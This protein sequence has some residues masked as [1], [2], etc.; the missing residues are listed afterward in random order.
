MK[1]LSISKHKLNAHGVYFCL[2]FRL[3]YLVK[4]GFFCGGG[5]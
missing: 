1:V 5:E 2:Y 3:S 4:S